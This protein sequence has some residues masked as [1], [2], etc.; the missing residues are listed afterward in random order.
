MNRPGRPDPNDFLTLISQKLLDL[1]KKLSDTKL[2]KDLKFIVLRFGIDIYNSL[3]A[4]DG[5]AK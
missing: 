5:C 3:A 2:G 1:L 4:M